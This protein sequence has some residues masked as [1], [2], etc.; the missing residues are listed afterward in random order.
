MPVAFS[1]SLLEYSCVDLLSGCSGI[2]K[3]V[4]LLLLPFKGLYHL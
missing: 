3:A 4:F 2:E 1:C